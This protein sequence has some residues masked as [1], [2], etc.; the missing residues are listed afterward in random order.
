VIPDDPVQRYLSLL[1]ED[2][3]DE[4]LWRPAMYY[5][6]S[7]AADRCLAGTRLAEE[8]V[9]VHGVLVGARRRWIARRQERLFVSGDGVTEANR[10]HV[11]DGYLNP[12]ERLE[13]IFS[14][15]AFMLGTRPTIAD[16]GL[17]GP[18]W[19][20]FVHDPTPARLIQERAPAVFEW[21]ARTWNARV[22][23]TGGEPLVAGIP[24]DW[25]PLL[26]EI[27]ETHLE[28]LAQN[29]AAF[30]AGQAR[31]DL[32]VQGV[33]YPGIPTSAYRPWCLRRLK[34]DFRRLPEDAASEVRNILEEH[35]CWEPLW[36]IT[37]FRCEH[38]PDGTGPFCRA[39]R[40]VRD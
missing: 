33:L 16:F 19:R 14:R 4:W 3:S 35:G 30:D 17:M 10:S 11:E 38:D 12:L 25:T 24:D 1:V 37:G 26:R 23:R 34:Q 18:F 21:A 28:A 36:R 15:R 39:T 40:M 5:R 9:R 20:H 22:S 29:A 8:I 13:A 7:Y 31:H 6:W 2:Y 32:H 27:G